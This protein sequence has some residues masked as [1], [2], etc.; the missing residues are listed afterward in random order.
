M[1][2]SLSRYFLFSILMM[3]FSASLLADDQEKDRSKPLESVTLQLKW[4]PQFQFAGY[5]AAL[6]QGFYEAEGLDVTIRPL[7]SNR[8]IINQVASGDIEYAVGGSGVLAHYANGSPLKALAAIFQHDALIFIARQSSGIISPYEMAGKRVMFDGVT[9]DDASLSAMLSDANI[10]KDSYLSVAPAY[11]SQQFIDGEIDVMS[12]YIT[13]QPFALKEQGVNVNI[14]NPQNYGIDFYGDILYT[15]EIE[16]NNNPGRAARF[17]RASLKG[18]QYALDNSEEIIQLLKQKYNS[19]SSIDALRYEAEQTRKLILADVIALGSIEKR[20]LRRVAD[21]YAKLGL[22]RPLD[23][24]LLDRFILGGSTPLMLTDAEQE[25]L[26]NHPVI[27]LGVDRDFAPYEWV[28]QQGNYTG[29]A[30]AYMQLLESRLGVRFEVTYD[31]PW[32][33][34]Q[35][36]AERGELDVLSCVNRTPLRDEFLNFTADYVSNPIVIVSAN[37]NGY[38]GSLDKL[39]GKTVAVERGYFTHEKLADNYPKINLLLVDSTNE[40]LESVSTGQADAYLGDAAFADYAIKKANLLNLQFA[41]QTADNSAYRVGVIKAHPELFSIINKALNSIDAQK[42]TEIERQWMGLQLETGIAV[43]TVAKIAAVLIF[44]II[45]IF[46]R[47]YRLTKE[48]NALHKVK[49]ELQLY[50]RV[51]SEAH[52]GIIITD[53]KN[54]IIDVNPK[55]CD[56]TGY[57]RDEVIGANPAMLSSGKQ[58]PEF[59][60]QMWDD[61][62]NDGHWNGEVWNRKKNGE[63]YAELL[64][65]S[66]LKDKQNEIKYYVGLFSDITQ[67]KRQ[68]E[69]LQLMA[70]YDVLTKLPNR[71]LFVDR[72]SQAIAHSK[73]SNS[74]LAVCFLDLDNFKPVND[75]Y[76]HEVG[77]RLLIEV[78]QRIQATIREED[79]VSRQG[80]D[81]FTLLLGDIDSYSQCEQMLTRIHYS[82]S[83][84]YLIDDRTINIGASSGVTLYPFDDSDIDTLVRHADQSMYQSKLAGKNRYHLFNAEQ[85]QEIIK[86]HIRL[87]EIQVA[88]TNN[89]FCLYYQPKVNMKSGEVFGVEA[90]IRWLHPEKG[91][92]PPM[93]FL[94]IIENTDLE[95]EMG[96]W[97]VAEAVKQLHK[98]QQENI[99]LEVSVNISSHHL[100]SATFFSQLDSILEKYPKVASHYLQLEILES[101]ALGD[102]QAVSSII[103]T[104]KQVLGVNIALDD[105]GTGYSSLTHLRSLPA[106]TIKIDQSFVRD[107]LDDPSDYAIIDGV[108]GLADSFNRA[109]IA[110]G[111]ETI[112]HGLMLLLMGCQNA[113]GY[114]IARP[115][116]AGEI[117]TW[118]DD[119][120]PNEEWIVCGNTKRTVKETK[121]KLLKV[122][123]EYW[124]NNVKQVTLNLKE[125]NEKH[126]LM[127][128][129]KSHHGFW[130]ERARQEHLFDESWLNSLAHEIETMHH[131]A[132]VLNTK[133]HASQHGDVQGELEALEMANKKVMTILL[134]GH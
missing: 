80:G 119:Y 33:E 70:H 124:F 50:G 36:M 117:S 46:A 49:D 10:N 43:D 123:L 112:E 19:D 118:L 100:Q 14:I 129:K 75:N 65:V 130:V 92:I 8:D 47:H 86:S 61:L 104:C 108:I 121:V 69:K 114:V 113:Q 20:R 97:V 22:A 32:H 3:C 62:D 52:E 120:A 68:Q 94:P 98:W 15:S 67:N 66:V 96:H 29:L 56:I 38:I 88:L 48:R 27:R 78:A 1:M 126:V 57:S 93:E 53:I 41:G 9:G 17:R 90:L 85:D 39:S 23:D 107:M 45:L 6:E 74:L 133:Y 71:T 11:S 44:I 116:P 13:D 64:T 5:Y 7:T 128:Y 105:F 40:A 54:M 12:A 16:I 79:T 110:E 102:L 91:L 18:W 131:L 83:Q 89:E 125:G 55:F 21:T 28:D 109:V 37:R 134:A 58:G 111:V 76:G 51:F 30:A 81:E 59:Y 127:D 25:W 77:D 60:Q 132:D 101:S 63:L 4:K 103:R 35:A 34:I 82:L 115:M 26:N 87:Q 42:R 95:V 72:F 122:M 106:N 31:K 84:P 73:R 99:F 2:S 24:Q